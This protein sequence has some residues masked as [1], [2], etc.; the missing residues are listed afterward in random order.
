MTATLNTITTK[1]W[2]VDDA[3][4][5]LKRF[6][7]AERELFRASASR[8]MVLASWEAKKLLPRHLWEDT[9]HADLLRGRVLEMRYPKRTV[10]QQPPI[11]LIRAIHELV[12]AQSD[13]E[14]L[15]AIT[16]VFKPVLIAAYERYLTQTDVLDDA[17]SVHHIQQILAEKR[18]QVDEGRQLLAA[19]PDSALDSSWISYLH[20]CVEASG[21]LFS[22]KEM[23]PFPTTPDYTN[24]AG[25]RRPAQFTR[26]PRF[27]PAL[28]HMPDSWGQVPPSPIASQVWLAISHANEMW[29]AE[30]PLMLAWE[31][32]EM[33]WEFYLDVGRWA[34]DETRHSAMGE[35]RLHAWGFEVGIDT[36]MVADHYTALAHTSPALL[37]ALLHDFETHGPSTKRQYKGTFEAMGDESSAQDCDYDWADEA[38]HLTYGLRWLRYLSGDE[39]TM[40]TLKQQARTTWNEWREAIHT[41]YAPF[42]ERIQT[43]IR[44]LTHTEGEV[45]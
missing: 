24:R 27:V 3:S 15:A 34:W 44:A 38:I 37:L 18:R 20:A 30:M 36:P 42:M 2:S 14:I 19:F 31:L 5:I 35:R 21:G 4:T 40:T 29:A 45:R 39:A 17:P 26:D 13:Q 11:D 25:Y 8:H 28:V 6:Y 43:R 23:V 1:R 12:K 9:V 33:P 32:A 22:D 41:D 10:D 7:W 16:L